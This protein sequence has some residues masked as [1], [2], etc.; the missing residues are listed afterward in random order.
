MVRCTDRK[1]HDVTVVF[2]HRSTLACR[3]RNVTGYSI[4]DAYGAENR[5]RSD[6]RNVMSFR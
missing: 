3:V 2:G 1:T 5:P 6:W 4:P